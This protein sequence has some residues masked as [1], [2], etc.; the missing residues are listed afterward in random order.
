ME[1]YI[2]IIT[3]AYLVIINIVSF[4]LMGI[5]KRRAKRG[6]WRISEAALFTSALLFG[7]L[8]STIGMWHFR[9]KTRHWYF[10]FGM[11]AILAIQIVLLVLLLTG[12]IE[13]FTL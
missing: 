1:K 8:G 7:G 10:V 11:P 4:T 2:V 9:H 5:D 3:C 6:E 12:P 13:F